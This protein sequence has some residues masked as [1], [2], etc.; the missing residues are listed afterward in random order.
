MFQLATKNH[1]GYV[2]QNID[3]YAKK[4]NCDSETS[5]FY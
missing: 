2:G 1:T 4:K 5:Y 3:I